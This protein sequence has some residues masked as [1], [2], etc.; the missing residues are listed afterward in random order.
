M[1]KKKILPASKV[2]IGNKQVN[3]YEALLSGM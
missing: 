3:V 1:E 2:V